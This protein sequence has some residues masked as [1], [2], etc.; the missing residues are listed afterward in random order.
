MALGAPPAR[1]SK[2]G[3]R[4]TAIEDAEHVLRFRQADQGTEIPHRQGRHLE[5]RA[6]IRRR[7]GGNQEPLAA[8]G[9]AVAGIPQQKPGVG[10]GPLDGEEFPERRP[11]G[12]GLGVGLQRDGEALALEFRRDET[13][14]RDGL[15]QTGP[16]V[17]VVVD[18]DDQGVAG[19]VEADLPGDRRAPNLARLDLD[20]QAAGLGRDLTRSHQHRRRQHRQ[21][22]WVSPHA[23]SLGPS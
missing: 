13:S 22:D 2:D 9:V 3:A 11:Q 16:A 20:G 8:D 23:P 4:E 14:V 6:G 18:A 1:A 21:E 5:R 10:I 19:A 12:F 15:R 7:V 17:C